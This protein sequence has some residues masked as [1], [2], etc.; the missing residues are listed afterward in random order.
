M[1]QPSVNQSIEAKHR[2]TLP[3]LDW[4]DLREPGCY[5][6]VASGDLYRVPQEALSAGMSPVIVKESTGASRLRQISK[7]PFMPTVQARIR[8][9]QHNIQPNF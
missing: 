7:D 2:E 5:V 9:A 3:E 6:D 8:A 1:P 4:Q